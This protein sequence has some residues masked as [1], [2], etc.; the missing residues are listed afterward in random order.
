MN[1]GAVEGKAQYIVSG[2][3]HHLLPLKEYQGIRILTPAQ[4]LEA[5]SLEP[6]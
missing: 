5:I 2:D 4:F 3:K 1:I 6:D